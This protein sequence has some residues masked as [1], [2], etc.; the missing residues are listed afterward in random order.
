M[1]KH[2][3]LKRK[4]A[5]LKQLIR[6]YEAAAKQQKNTGYLHPI[7]KRHAVDVEAE[8]GKAKNILQDFTSNVKNREYQHPSQNGGEAIPF[9][10][11]PN[12]HYTR[13]GIGDFF[14]Q[15]YTNQEHTNVR[16]LHGRDKKN[17]KSMEKNVS[18]AL[19]G[20]FNF[21][22]EKTY[23]VNTIGVYDLGRTRPLDQVQN[24]TPHV[25]GNT[26]AGPNTPHT[27]FE[28]DAILSDYNTKY[29]EGKPK[30]VSIRKAIDEHFNNPEGAGYKQTHNNTSVSRHRNYETVV[31]AKYLKDKQIG[32]IIQP[33]YEKGDTKGIKVLK[34][35]TGNVMS[36]DQIVDNYKSFKI[37]RDEFN[38]AANYNSNSREDARRS[39]ELNKEYFSDKI[40]RK[41]RT[42]KVYPSYGSIDN[43][44]ESN[45]LY[46]AKR[47][48]EDY[49]NKI[50]IMK[51]NS[52]VKKKLD[53]IG[54]LLSSNKFLNENAPAIGK[55]FYAEL[56]KNDGR[57]KELPQVKAPYNETS[58]W[59]G[60][61]HY[62]DPLPNDVK[63]Q[64][65]FVGRG[66]S[67]GTSRSESVRESF[68]PEDQVWT[69]PLIFNVPPRYANANGQM[70]DFSKPAYYSTH[71]PKRFGKAVNPWL[72]KPIQ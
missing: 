14:R 33:L 60:A 3:L 27:G 38:R 28:R 39:S 30:V 54:T 65:R 10:K 19:E 55:D 40:A 62:K 50:K 1:N 31:R 24:P 58:R 43:V 36:N 51:D 46:G 72:E 16:S 70:M 2:Q 22:E 63:P 11:H 4:A 42:G 49:D 34:D 32:K 71:D 8:A 5:G 66:E 59:I 17:V 45:S 13:E 37:P 48:R 23:P 15:S 52:P 26:V 47:Y 67:E 41:K 64:E 53:D 29:R 21:T 7:F 9:Y 35:E 57:I 44:I 12:R 20:R 6:T 56:E 61:N 18:N 25:M 68:S 69:S